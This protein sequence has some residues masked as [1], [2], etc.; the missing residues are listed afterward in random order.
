MDGTVALVWTPYTCTENCDDDD[1]GTLVCDDSTNTCCN[2]CAIDSSG[3]WDYDLRDKSC[4]EICGN[5]ILVTGSTK[6]C[7]DGQANAG[8][9]YFGDGCDWRCYLEDTS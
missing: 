6:E 9:E 5:G 2:G 1:R 8:D 3:V 7:E 4:T